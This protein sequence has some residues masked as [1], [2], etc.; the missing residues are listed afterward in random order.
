[1]RISIEQVRAL[2]LMGVEVALELF[3]EDEFTIDAFVERMKGK[4]YDSDAET[5]LACGLYTCFVQAL[6][7]F[8]KDGEYMT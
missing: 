6:C 5:D 1:M 3:Q 2:K 4:G 8:L 7:G